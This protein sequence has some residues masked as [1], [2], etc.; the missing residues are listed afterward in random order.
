M[1]G[2]QRIALAVVVLTGPLVV[3]PAAEATTGHPIGGCATRGGWEPVHYAVSDPDN[4]SAIA[5]DVTYGNGDGWLCVKT[6]SAHTPYPMLVDNTV[7]T[8]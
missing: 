7:P 3:A 2:K 5:V 4:G 6:P 1:T 8:R